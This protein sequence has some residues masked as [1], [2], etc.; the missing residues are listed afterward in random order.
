MT[1][2]GTVRKYESTEMAAAALFHS[3][4]HNH[5]FHNGNKRTALV[6]LLA[7]LDEN[8]IVITSSEQELFRFTLRTAQHRLVQTGADE[9]A[10][11]EVLEV[12][13]WVSSNSRPVE[14]GERPMKWIRLKQRL[15]DFGCDFEPARGVGNRINIDRSIREKGFLGRHK[16][17]VLH[18]QV[19]WAGDGTEADRNTLHKIRADLELDDANDCDS[20]T[21][22][23]GAEIDSF[24]ID[25][26]RILGRLA[27]L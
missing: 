25:H 27:K 18:T 23:Q 24:I 5:A 8:G 26:R 14:K 17:R 1:S 10:D 7:F 19:R 16:T 3:L 4:V 15:R 21:F 2:L 13:K 20:A 9:L 12:A 22:Y 11:R 6:A